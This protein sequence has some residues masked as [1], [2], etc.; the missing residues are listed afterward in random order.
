MTLPRRASALITLLVL[1]LAGC[2]TATTT[3]GPLKA[4][5]TTTIVSVQVAPEI[6]GKISEIDVSQADNVQA[7]DV[8]FKLDDQLLQAQVAQA[9]AAVQVAQANVDLAQNKLA[10]A[11]VQYAEG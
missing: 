3:S 8:L 6:S 7:G 10:S 4:S 1:F 5:G 9:N 2:S 11:Q